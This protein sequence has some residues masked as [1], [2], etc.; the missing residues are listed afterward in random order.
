[1]GRASSEQVYPPL[2]ADVG[3]LFGKHFHPQLQN[4]V[5]LNLVACMRGCDTS[6]AWPPHGK[7]SW[8][9]KYQAEKCL[10]INKATIDLMPLIAARLHKAAR[11]FKGL[12]VLLLQDADRSVPRPAGS[13][14][15]HA[16]EANTTVAR[17]LSC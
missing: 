14:A 3:G 8:R 12:P 2:I 13:F 15:S 7:H 11:I 4:R 16:L 10:P 17:T 5:P 6:R 1:M 9:G